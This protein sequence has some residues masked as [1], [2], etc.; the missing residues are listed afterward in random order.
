MIIKIQRPLIFPEGS[1][2]EVLIYNQDRSFQIMAP[3]TQF[4][5]LFEGPH[6]DLKIYCEAHIVDGVL[7]IDGQ[8]EDQDW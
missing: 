3:S 1:Q 4:E 6:P 2:P 7:V 5:H 8:V